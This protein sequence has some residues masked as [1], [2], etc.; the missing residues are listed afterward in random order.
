MGLQIAIARNDLV[1]TDLLIAPGADCKPAKAR[2]IPGKLGRRTLDQ[3]ERLWP[4][5]VPHER[6]RSKKL[7][8]VFARQP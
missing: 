8:Q 4:F 7:Y 2:Q 1:A 6:S 3:A 5:R